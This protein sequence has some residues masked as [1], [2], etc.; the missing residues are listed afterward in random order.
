MDLTRAARPARGDATMTPEKWKIAAVMLAAVAALALGEALVARGMRQVGG[1]GAGWWAGARAAAG[2]GWVVAGVLLLGLHLGL[3]AT[4]LA[5]ADLSLVMPLTAASYP[6]GTL[7]ARYFLREVVNPARWIGTVV[8][9]V[10]VAL[11]AWGES[12]SPR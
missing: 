6:L 2:N 9:T 4:A 8:I 1:S 11:I 10:G 3:Y 5:E 12:R 7:L